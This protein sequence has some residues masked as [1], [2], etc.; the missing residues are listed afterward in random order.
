MDLIAEQAAAA[1]EASAPAA[2]AQTQE[3]PK[4]AAA[5]PT[6]AQPQL[7][8]KKA[9]AAKEIAI[10]AHAERP[11]KSQVITAVKTDLPSVDDA[12]PPVSGEAAAPVSA[13]PAAPTAAPASPPT[14]V[15]VS[16]PCPASVPARMVLGSVC[17]PRSDGQ[18]PAWWDPWR[19][20]CRALGPDTRRCFADVR[21]LLPMQ[22]LLLKRTIDAA[23]GHHQAY[24]RSASAL[25]S[26]PASD[27]VLNTG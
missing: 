16:A 14:H 26:W 27:W 25:F 6:Q 15:S 24:R 20:P 21:C 22:L 12:A 18:G 8:V 23:R 9:D 13:P 3:E 1:E 2:E 19:A 5:A 10:V 17:T 11:R 4:V 7:A